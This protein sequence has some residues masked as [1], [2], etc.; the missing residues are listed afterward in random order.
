MQDWLDSRLEWIRKGNY[1]YTLFLFY[2]GQVRQQAR[3]D[4]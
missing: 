3:A 4:Y 2:T 1:T